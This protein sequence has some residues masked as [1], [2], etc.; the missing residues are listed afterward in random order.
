M[1]PFSYPP[2]PVPNFTTLQDQIVQDVVSLL[3][4]MWAFLAL[5]TFE[6]VREERLLA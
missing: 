6:W 2:P 4:D 1:T 5:L 3:S